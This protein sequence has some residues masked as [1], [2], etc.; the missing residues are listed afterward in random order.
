MIS[1]AFVRCQPQPPTGEHWQLAA[2]LCFMML[3]ILLRLCWVRSRS[4]GRMRDRRS[5]R[6]SGSQKN[7]K[8]N[9]LTV[10]LHYSPGNFHGRLVCC[11]FFMV[12]KEGGKQGAPKPDTAKEWRVSEET[13]GELTK[14]FGELDA[15]T[16]R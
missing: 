12:E 5:A 6:C 10:F 4:R 16:R 1:P 9:L 7:S 8:T 15:N 2:R 13:H 14:R 3:L 11:L